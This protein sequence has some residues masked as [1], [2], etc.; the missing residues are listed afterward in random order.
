VGWWVVVAGLL[1]APAAVHGQVDLP[2][3][4]SNAAIVVSAPSAQRWQQGSYD[5]WVLQ[6]KCQIRQGLDQA[7]CDEAVLWVDRSARTEQG[8]EKI[9]AYLEGHVALRRQ[10]GTQPTTLTDETWFGR[11]FGDRVS[12]DVPRVAGPPA[13]KPAI[14]RRGMARWQP[15]SARAIQR[16]QHVQFEATP[17]A[18]PPGAMAAPLRRIRINPRG[19]GRM[20]IQGKPGPSGLDSVGVITSGVNLVVHG[21]SEDGT[22][23]VE[24]DRLVIWT[25]GPEQLRSGTES[26]QSEDMPLE[27]YMEGNIVFRQ[28]Q[29]TIYAERM[30][31][32]VRR[33]VGMVL[34]AEL[35]TP[36]PRYEGLLRLRSE[37]LH[38]T[39][40]NHYFAENSFVTSS[41]M[42]KPGYRIQLGDV[43]LEDF[44]QPAF[45]PAT[46]VQVGTEAQQQ[47]TG[48]HSFLFLGDVPVFYWPY[49]STS[50]EDPTFYIRRAQYKNDRVFGNQILTTWNGYQLFGIKKEPEGTD[51]DLSLDYLSK[52]GLGHGAN[53]SYNRTGLLDFPGRNVGLVDFWGI[54]DHGL[55]NLGRERRSL[56]PEKSYRHRL[57]WQHRQELARDW[58]LSAEVGWISDRNFLEQYYKNEWDELKDETTGIELKRRVDNTS[59]ALSADTRLNS[60]FTQTEW[61]PRLDHYWL[62]QPLF[63][64]ALTW[65]EHSQAG[66]GRYRIVSTPEN[67][68][69]RAVFATLPWEQAAKG[70]RLVTTQ[71]IDWPL[72]FGP[73]KAVPY[74]LGQL[75]HWGAD[76]A[77]EDVQRTYWQAGLRASLPMWRVDPSVENTLWNVHG[78]A[79][80]IV[81]DAEFSVAEADRDLDT[82]PLYDP[83]DDDSIE[84]FRRR[85]A[86]WTFGTPPAPLT[87]NY[88][89]RFD[90]RYYAV[91]SG[92]PGWV[93][94]PSVETLDDMMA[95][96]LG[97]RQRWQTKR[98]M[99]GQRHIIDWITFDTGAVWFPDANRDNF[100]NSIGLV[101]YDFQWHVGDRLTLVSDGLFDFFDDGQQ[102]VSVG[103]FLSRPPRGNLYLGMRLLEG[104]INARVLSMSYS[105]RMSPKW[106]SAFGMSI[107]LGDTGNIGQR[108]TITR[109]GESL[110]VSA[111]F[112]IDATRGDVGAVF[113][114]EPRFLPKT[115]LGRAGGASVPVAGTY[116]LE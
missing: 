108:L 4:E 41:R 25:V 67:P 7:E 77:G 116:G 5:V 46:G 52:R 28:G 56:E 70:E 86:F 109:I 44:Q 14:Y 12:M 32:D 3:S 55:D 45:D 83:L 9:I 110:L 19:N 62:G 2:P 115:R 58:Q 82:L 18:I 23:D 90:P 106:V 20:Q 43:E 35:L 98:G 54:K 61:Y 99:P 71:E 30:Y 50:L 88:P 16:T 37:V 31:Y 29:R 47:L 81:F 92:L 63:G 91:R 87:P 21:V 111:G 76:L 93:T 73:V 26:L 78:L 22:I 102:V 6:G 80:K 104:P 65:H 105:Y 60:F 8:R 100:G 113:S 114:I 51:F 97:M 66:Y 59:L 48:H 79:H 53:F 101:N 95:M 27:V 15:E 75:A 84:A 42:G 96:R 107:D 69:D 40:E 36:V 112:S 74:A 1:I 89:P 10:I 34:G 68:A 49:V 103:G 38:Q 11:F 24:T 13:E 33:K 72:Q 64:D 17:E 94:S 85:L 39:D 57:F